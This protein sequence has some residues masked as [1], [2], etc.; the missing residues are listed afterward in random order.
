[1][2]HRFGLTIFVLIVAFYSCNC[3]PGG[4]SKIGSHETTSNNQ[5]TIKTWYYSE[6]FLP[7]SQALSSCFSHKMELTHF[8]S[9]QDK[10][11]LSS[12]YHAFTP[13]PQGVWVGYTDEGHEGYWTDMYNHPP[14]LSLDFQAN[15]PTNSG[16]DENC[17][18]MDNI[19]SFFSFNDAKCSIPRPY[20]C[21]K[22]ET[23]S[24]KVDERENF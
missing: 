22:I 7:W 2:N 1:M 21:H 10:E 14:K 18:H 16:G 8:S 11:T 6:Y 5:K 12:L 15:E 23:T 13:H 4:F 3:T 24:V 17:L 9:R 19:N 20:I